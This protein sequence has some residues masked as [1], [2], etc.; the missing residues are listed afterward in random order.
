[1][2][3]LRQF[4]TNGKQEVSG[5]LKILR[6]SNGGESYGDAVKISE[7]S[8]DWLKFSSKDTVPNVAVDPGSGPFSDNLYGVWHYTKKDSHGKSVGQVSV[9][10]YSSDKGNT[11]STPERID[12]ATD[13]NPGSHDEYQP[14]VAVNKD[15]VV[16]V[17]WY[18]GFDDSSTMGYW[19]RFTASLDG[20]QTWSPS[21]RV[22]EA[23]NKIGGTEEWHLRGWTTGAEANSPL[24]IF[25]RP[26]V[27]EASGH[28][29]GLV[30]D[31]NG[32]FHAFWVDNRTGIKEVWTAPIAVGGPVIKNG[33]NELASFDDLS[34]KTKIDIDNINV[35]RVSGRLS[36][37]FQLTNISE[38]TIIG[39]LKLRILNME[40]DLGAPQILN[41]ENH[42]SGFGAVLDLS[43]SFAGP[44]VLQPHQQSSGK[45]L[46][47]KIDHLGPLR[48]D[49]NWNTH[50]LS[51]TARL[52]GK[53]QR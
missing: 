29:A 3:L 7:Y 1:M 18:D 38:Q 25:V 20:G 46:E 22:S 23:P 16:G 11:W 8:S 5:S 34:S 45:V 21:V 24:K 12:N 39:P 31:A 48:S 50:L 13:I 47:F 44:V 30:A 35:D 6:S 37:T 26:F 42:V 36:A 33:A 43:D 49:G 2:T 40:S 15:G 14:T 28:T 53:I 9:V 41:A 10:S 27:W 32:V 19:V 4:E 51:I 17:M 52:F